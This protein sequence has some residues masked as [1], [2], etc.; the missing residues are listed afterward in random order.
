MVIG[1][2]ASAAPLPESPPPPP[3]AVQAN[4]SV[5]VTA[6]AR[7]DFVTPSLFSLPG[8]LTQRPEYFGVTRALTP[9]LTR[10]A[11]WRRRD[12][13][14]G[15]GLNRQRSHVSRNWLVAAHRHGCHRMVLPC[16]ESPGHSGLDSSGGSVGADCH[17]T[18]VQSNDITIRLGSTFARWQS[19]A[20]PPSGVIDVD[21]RRAVHERPTLQDTILLFAMGVRLMSDSGPRSRMKSPSRHPDRSGAMRPNLPICAAGFGNSA[22]AGMTGLRG[23]GSD[24]GRGARLGGGNDGWANYVP[25]ES[26][27]FVSRGVMTVDRHYPPMECVRSARGRRRMWGWSTL[28]RRWSPSP[29]LPVSRLRCGYG[30]ATRGCIRQRSRRR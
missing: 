23:T 9:P 4:V 30:D 19:C 7:A 1:P 14:Q 22:G 10:I 15:P 12:P 6:T 2:R 8:G 29:V 27:L 25:G 11:A 21:R 24:V 17:A 28:A 5:S 13:G 16:D 20:K 3:Q 18:G 26:V